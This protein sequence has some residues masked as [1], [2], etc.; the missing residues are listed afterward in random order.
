M[1]VAGHGPSLHNPNPPEDVIPIHDACKKTVVSGTMSLFLITV[2][3]SSP[4]CA[5]EGEK[6][7]TP[8]PGGIPA[9]SRQASE[10]TIQITAV[11]EDE[12]MFRNVSW[13]KPA[14]GFP[15]R[16]RTEAGAA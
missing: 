3:V 6:G 14:E 13:V 4:E 15:N 16:G 11:P 2:L 5:I 9:A 1:I 10:R 12:A 8:V 7:S